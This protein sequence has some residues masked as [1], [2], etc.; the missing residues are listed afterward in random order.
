MEHRHFSNIQ[1][2]K[3]ETRALQFLIYS[4]VIFIL[5][6]FSNFLLNDNFTRLSSLL[7]L[8]TLFSLSERLYSLH[9]TR[10]KLLPLRLRPFPFRWKNFLYHPLTSHAFHFNPTKVRPFHFIWALTDGCMARQH[11]SLFHFPHTQVWCQFTFYAIE[12]L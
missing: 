10:G 8:V 4:G 12:R 3:E 6:P 9:L 5:T 11:L 2:I 7:R 1:I